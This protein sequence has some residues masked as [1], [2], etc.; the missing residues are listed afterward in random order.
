MLS[1]LRPFTPPAALTWSNHA[2]APSLTGLQAEATVPVSGFV[3]PITIVSALTP[4]ASE[5]SAASAPMEPAE[6]TTAATAKAATL[7]FL[8]SAIKLPSRCTPGK[9]RSQAELRQDEQFG[10]LLVAVF[11]RCRA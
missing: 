4:A 10:A 11:C 3:V 9:M 1:I 6:R 7:F 2:R 8:K 5:P